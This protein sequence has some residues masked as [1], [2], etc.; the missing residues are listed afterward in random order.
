MGGTDVLVHMRDKT[1]TNRYLVDVKQ[2]EGMKRISL[3]W[4]GLTLGAAVTMN[5]L[6][7]SSAVNQ[8]CPLLA[9]AARTVASYPLRNRA[10][11]VGNLCNASPAG[12]TTGACIVLRG[13]LHVC[14]PAGNRRIPLHA[15][16]VGPGRTALEPGDVATELH[17]P[18][19]PMGHI[20][21][22]KKLGRNAMGDLAI[23]G[24]TV[25]GHPD[26]NAVSGARFRLALASVAPIPLVPQQA[27]AILSD[28]PLT[29][30]TIDAAAEAAMSACSPIDDVRATARYRRLMV[31]NLT[32]QALMEVWEQLSAQAGRR[33]RSG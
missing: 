7:A 8:A 21:S 5:Q 26:T 33:P 24:V 3:D 15:L 13:T 9:Q 4:T 25:L 6:I 27:E 28:R 10:T 22:Y 23:V 14:G 30:A 1:C 31:R 29:P 16:F 18:L 17:F 32:R 20:A 19:P 12:D 11:V 2:L